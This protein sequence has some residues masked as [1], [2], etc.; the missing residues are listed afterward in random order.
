[1]SV[2]MLLGV[3]TC[4]G[5]TSISGVNYRIGVAVNS[6]IRVPTNKSLFD[7]A[8]PSCN[9]G[10]VFHAK[11][12]GGVYLEDDPQTGW[13]KLPVKTII[14][15]STG[16][17]YCTNSYYVQC[18]AV[19]GNEVYYCQWYYGTYDYGNIYCY[20]LY[21]FQIEDV[22]VGSSVYRRATYTYDRR[23]INNAITHTWWPSRTTLPT[24]DVRGIL[25]SNYGTLAIGLKEN[26][27]ANNIS[28]GFSSLVD[29]SQNFKCD[30]PD[31]GFKYGEY[32]AYLWGKEVGALPHRMSTGLHWAYFNAFDRLPA[33]SCNTLAN[34]LDIVSAIVS[35]KGGYKAI[36]GLTSLTR[37]A[38][39]GWR[40]AYNTTKMDIEEYASLVERLLALSQSTIDCY[41][42]HSDDTGTFRCKVTFKV[43]DV[44]PSK[45]M[46]KLQQFGLKLSLENVW[47]IIPYSFVVDWFFHIGDILSDLENWSASLKLNPT[48]IWYSFESNYTV[49]GVMQNTYLR[50]CSQTP[51]QLPVFRYRETSTRTLFM[52]VLDAGAL[53]IQ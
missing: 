2:A 15:G 25:T 36:S 52:R 51:P 49:N 13:P 32:N 20:R 12:V 40:Y 46:E 22:K 30:L 39:L 1:M 43:S 5:R 14:G 23:Y 27:S 34:I 9:D 47:D 10:N 42:M 11:L 50:L 8:Q 6:A 35:F 4:W 37:E 21:D 7:R 29:V 17:Y 48:N 53:L 16:W 38:W 24:I 45:T 28:G 41:G 26:S 18:H 44:I 31:F 3:S 33:A 19:Y